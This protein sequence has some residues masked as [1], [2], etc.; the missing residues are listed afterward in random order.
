MVITEKDIRKIAFIAIIALFVVL[1][2]FIIR[3]VFFSLFGGL[4]LAYI[5][6]PVHK[7]LLKY[8]KIKAVSAAIVSI[9]AV[10]II[11]VPLW[12]ILP[13][14]SQQ[15]FELYKIS[16]N[17][18]LT[19]L[20]K[21]VFRTTSDQFASQIDLTVKNAFSKVVTSIINSIL[22]FLINFAILTLHL[23]LLVFVFFFTLKDEEKLRNFASGLLPFGKNQERQFIKQFND[24]TKSILYG[25][26]V[27]GIIQGLLAAALLYLFRVPNALVL[28]FIAL[29]LSIIPVIGPGFVYVPVT[30]YLA[31]AGHPVM[32]LAYFLLNLLVVSPTDSLFRSH[33]VSRR[34]NISQAIILIGMIGGLFVFN[35][36]GI[37]LGPLILAYLITFLKA[38]KENTLSSF[39]DSS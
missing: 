17:L 3:P 38:Y 4:I 19:S 16:Q 32:A 36:L 26:I 14:V 12:F 21:T 11:V 1:S 18:E 23:L 13:L 37:I 31:I 30:I 28:S 5:F 35:I 6:M 27:A 10:A 33:F 24:I 8:V 2:F 9:L 7:F 15:V 22:D 29:I 25:Q 34:T 20:I 39:F